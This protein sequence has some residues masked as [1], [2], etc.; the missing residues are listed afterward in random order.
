MFHTHLVRLAHSPVPQVPSSLQTKHPTSDKIMAV[1]RT[2][3]RDRSRGSC[4]GQWRVSRRSPACPLCSISGHAERGTLVYLRSKAQH[5]FTLCGR[6]SA[7]AST[8]ESL[9]GVEDEVQDGVLVRQ[10]GKRSHHPFR[11]C[12]RRIARRIRHSGSQKELK[13]RTQQC[14]S[15]CDVVR[16]LRFGRWQQCALYRLRRQFGE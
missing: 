7:S 15:C 12:F 8:D 16:N 13:K 9:V 11:R 3:R 4:S 2:T 14:Q 6:R 5:T 1:A 10:L